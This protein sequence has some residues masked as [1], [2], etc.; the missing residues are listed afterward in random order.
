[1]MPGKYKV[2]LNKDTYTIWY[3]P[4]WEKVDQKH[5]PP[6]YKYL[7]KDLPQPIIS[8]SSVAGVKVRN[9]EYSDRICGGGAIFKQ[10]IGKFEIHKSGDYMI[11]SSM[12]ND[13]GNYVIA[14]VPSLCHDPNGTYSGLGGSYF[15]G[16]EEP[17]LFEFQ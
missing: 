5:F 6:V 2:H 17:I 16:S 8:I 12:K 1:M 14:V 13:A 11:Q 9:Q 15:S 3:Y 10:R 7:H 4:H